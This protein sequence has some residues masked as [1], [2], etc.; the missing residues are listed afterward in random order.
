MA[1]G[2]LTCSLCGEG[3]DVL[4]TNLMIFQLGGERSHRTRNPER[5]CP[6]CSLPI[7]NILFAV[8]N[9]L[10]TPQTLFVSTMRAEHRNPPSKE[11]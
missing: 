3:F 7:Q 5:L 6:K 10:A 4:S 11:S 9:Q 2:Q 8:R 1:I